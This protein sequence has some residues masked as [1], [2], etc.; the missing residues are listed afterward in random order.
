[1][2]KIHPSPDNL[3]SALARLRDAA[4]ILDNDIAPLGLS[5]IKSRDRMRA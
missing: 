4:L 1:M 3:P 2:T 5:W